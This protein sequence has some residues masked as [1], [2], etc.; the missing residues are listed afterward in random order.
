MLRY[1]LFKNRLKK[2]HYPNLV[3]CEVHEVL[4][5]TNSKTRNMIWIIV[6]ALVWIVVLYAITHVRPIPD[7]GD[8]E[9]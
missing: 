1:Y 9:K 3:R 7:D 8:F 4:Q 6:I 5:K 2:K